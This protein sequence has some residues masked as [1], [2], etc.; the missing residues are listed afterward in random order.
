MARRGAGRTDAREHAP[1]SPCVLLGGW[2]VP[3]SPVVGG[4]GHAVGV[5][6]CVPFVSCLLL[7]PVVW[8]V[9]GVWVGWL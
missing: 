7:P 8:G 5:W 6:G 3:A 2:G 4:W 1:L 9:V